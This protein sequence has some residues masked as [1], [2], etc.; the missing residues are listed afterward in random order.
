MKRVKGAKKAGSLR[1]RIITDF[2]AVLV[3]AFLI[4][5]TVIAFNARETV[6][7]LNFDL[8][9]QVVL[10]RAAEIGKYI[11]GIVNDAKTWAGRDII[12]SGNLEVIRADLEARQEKL[13]PD[14]LMVF[15]SDMEGNYFSSMGASGSIADRD[16]FLQI[17]ENGKD[18]A[19]SNPVESRSTG[20]TI[21]SVAHVVTDKQGNRI[22]V[23]TITILLDTFNE[24]VN[25]IKIGDAG[26]PWIV[27]GTGLVIAHPDD[28]LRLKQ[29]VLSAESGLTG[30][31][32]MAEAMTSGGEGRGQYTDAASKSY[33]AVYAPIPGAPNWSMVYS[34]SQNEM[35]RPVNSLTGTVLIVLAAVLPA[36]A[37]VALL[38]A[39]R[40]V[41]PAREAARLAGDLANG[42]LESPAGKH[43]NDEVG[44]L[45]EIL[46]KQVRQ[47][48][49]TI[50][51][52]RSR[53]TKQA[54]Y[55]ASEA[56]KLLGALK[57]FAQGEL[58]V[59][60]KV[61]EGDADTVELNALFHEIA[62]NLNSALREIQN[63]ISEIADTLGE[64]AQ[65]NMTVA[66][67][68]EY[69]GDFVVL[70]DSINHIAQTI[71]GVLV[72]I[73]IAAEQVAAG[74][75]QVSSGSQNISQG[76]TEQ[77]SSIEELTASVSQIAAQTREN[78]M[79]ANKARELSAAAASGAQRGGARMEDMQQAMRE[80]SESSDS[81]Q[82][83][84]KVID[85][86]AF[87]TN[88]LALNAAVEAARAGVHGKGFAVVAE[89]VRNLAQRSAA[90][91]KETTQ[92]IESSM[93]KTSAGEKLANQTA[94]ALV[95]IVSGVR[96][97]A[98][99]VEEIAQASGEQAT[100][101]S[102]VDMGVGQMSQVV[103]TNSATSEETAAAAQELSGQA[104]LLRNMVGR[105]RVKD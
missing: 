12:S 42:V 33:Y 100:A 66:I 94:E 85:D 34:I 21:F 58:A 47:A 31:E 61:D 87:Q 23:F 22:G 64:M 59:R 101:I 95:E 7:A 105:F 30:F 83:I 98:T 91:A 76:A 103:Q 54:A 1:T 13:R 5:G 75:R 36:A 40:I 28:A 68:S 44:R 84:I 14:Y 48:F 10:A 35:M 52:A 41:K 49:L 26:F 67:E 2:L 37:V 24:V 4:M 27:D 81:I 18:Y 77:A 73:G 19:I 16:Y 29:N 97:A 62:G 96:S 90:A 65:G 38:L 56:D 6:S 15:Y 9:E 25:N 89:E 72:E 11:D 51:Q 88:I 32:S 93:Q 3:V 82:K 17:A 71:N 79:R 43:T 50:E 53:A 8:T 63:Y 102:Q 104:E 80:I 74:T 92:L 70:K 45:T 46:D 60:V 57:S 99:L 55:Q 20:K 86:I 69:K 78:A 39:S